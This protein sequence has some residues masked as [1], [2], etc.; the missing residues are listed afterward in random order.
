M[1]STDENSEIADA[2]GTCAAGRTSTTDEKRRRRDESSR[3]APKS[4]SSPEE[5]GAWSRPP[6]PA[7]TGSKSHSDSDLRRGNPDRRAPVL[8]P[9]RRPSPGGSSTVAG[10][11]VCSRWRAPE[12]IALCACTN[13]YAWPITVHVVLR[14]RRYA[15]QTG[16][17]NKLPSRPY[18]EACRCQLTQASPSLSAH[19]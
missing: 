5:E 7:E 10:V 18:T 4:L 6:P 13:L 17:K 14:I 11:L 15:S 19:K 2:Y 1:L 9:G 8:R 12:A 3:T 16:A